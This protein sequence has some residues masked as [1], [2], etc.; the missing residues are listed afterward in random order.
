[1]PSLR[2]I[3]SEM[4][5]ALLGGD[6]GPART[7][8]R[9]DGLEPAARL[10]IYR[11]HV[12]TT[13]TAAL[14]AT[15]PV[16]CRLVDERFFAYAADRYI[17]VEP[18][19]GPC[20]FEYG[21]GF[22][23]FLAGFPPCRSLPYL[24]DV[25]RLE[26]AMQRALH[27][28]DAIP[29]PIRA[30]QGVAPDLAGSLTLTLDPSVTL[31]SSRY[32]VDRIWRANQVDEPEPAVVNL[33]DGGARLEIRRSGDDVVFRALDP[34]VFVFRHALARGGDLAAATAEALAAD[35]AFDLGSA[36]TALFADGLPIAL[37]PTPSTPGDDPCQREP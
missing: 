22:A 30:I 23:N 10:A 20:L 34:A 18:P 7:M 5:L 15:F 24:A 25:A 19:S 4:R 29:L 37:G 21:A 11:H 32:P 12:V 28:P 3:E 36:L 14:Q 31:L 26:W 27:A 13:L 9:G 17:Q 33:A 16:V 35:P 1:V 6:D 8:V 2:E